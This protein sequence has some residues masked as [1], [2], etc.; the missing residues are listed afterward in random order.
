MKKLLALAIV[1]LV[2]SAMPS[3]A[4]QRVRS[5]DD[6]KVWVG[7]G[8]NR[9]A[10]IVDFGVSDSI[11]GDVRAF[12]WGFRWNDEDYPAKPATDTMP[13]MPAGPTGSD[14]LNA[15]AK[16]MGNV[17]ADDAS[18]IYGIIYELASGEYGNNRI[19]GDPENGYEEFGESWAYYG[20]GGRQNCYVSGSL[21]GNVELANGGTK[22]PAAWEEMKC[23][24]LER[25]LT[26]GAW[27]AWVFARFEVSYDPSLVDEW[28]REGDFVV[29]LGDPPSDEV[30]QAQPP[31]GTINSIYETKI[32][33]KTS[34]IKKMSLKIK[35]L[36]GETPVPNKFNTAKDIYYR[37]PV[38]KNYTLL[39]TFNGRTDENHTHTGYGRMWSAADKNNP[40]CWLTFRE[41]YIREEQTLI[42]N[43]GQNVP[44]TFT[45]KDGQSE[46]RFTGL[47]TVN[48][49]V[50]TFAGDGGL[51]VAVVTSPNGF[52]TAIAGSVVGT[53]IFPARDPKNDESKKAE[54]GIKNTEAPGAI[55]SGTDIF[56]HEN[57]RVENIYYP[58]S[59]V[60]SRDDGATW[61]LVPA[62]FHGTFT[63]RA[64][65]K[66]MK[67]AADK[68]WTAT[69]LVESKL[70]KLPVKK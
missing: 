37:A 28:G 33:A 64:N 23:G 38:S 69:E 6:I 9:A 53:N 18:F 5:F 24:I 17:Q 12:A 65:A 61:E 27:D 4:Q 63:T 25:T 56:K 50:P 66:M 15:I 47:A 35:K 44:V 43:K 21:S 70:P 32:A 57:E 68:N 10:L 2:A 42:G 34:T 55:K 11:D 3:T 8:K 49:T 22:F 51:A 48:A 1:A 39:M 41:A 62:H 26:D 45:Y 30:Y 20:A 40:D 16:N 52:T 46:L 36:D 13:P 29:S 60:V 7:S 54:Q 58:S 14:M 67:E 19:T 59:C 31:E